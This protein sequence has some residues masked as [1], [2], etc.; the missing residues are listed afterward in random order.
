ML[1]SLNWHF[2]FFLKRQ[3]FYISA[4]QLSFCITAKLLS[5]HLDRSVGA[6]F[7]EFVHCVW[8]VKL[9]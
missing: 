8:N 1:S 3:H 4:F 5:L 9:C 7:A 6:S 2:T